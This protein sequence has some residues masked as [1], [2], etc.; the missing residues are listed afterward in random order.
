L[1]LYAQIMIFVREHGRLIPL[2]A[3]LDMA[4]IERGMRWWERFS[5]RSRLVRALALAAVAAYGTR[6]QTI[7]LMPSLLQM[8]YTNL[9]VIRK[10]RYPRNLLP[11]LLNTNCSSLSA[12]E[13]VSQ[14]CMSGIFYVRDGELREGRSSSYLLERD[15]EEARLRSGKQGERTVPPGNPS[16]VPAGPR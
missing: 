2:T 15:E 16:E 3:F 14:R 5:H 11:I 4:R 10:E 13:D 12:D 6:V 9:F 7:R 8:V 1:C